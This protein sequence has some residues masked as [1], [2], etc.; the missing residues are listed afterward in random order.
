MEGEDQELYMCGLIPA[1]K[2]LLEWAESFG[3]VPISQADVEGLRYSNLEEDPVIIS[4][5][6]W[7]YF[8]ANLTGAAKEIYDNVEMYQGFEVWR[9]ISQKINVWGERRRDEMAEIV[10]NPKFTGKVSG[11]H[12]QGVRSMGHEPPLLCGSRRKSFAGR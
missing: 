9:K 4:H 6:M 10:N 12:G 7:N 11:G 2:P 3:K 1:V 5:L 8:D